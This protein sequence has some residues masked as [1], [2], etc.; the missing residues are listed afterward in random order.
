MKDEKDPPLSADYKKSQETGGPQ[1]PDWLANKYGALIGLGAVALIAALLYGVGHVDFSRPQVNP[2]E[3]RP[4]FAAL[5][6]HVENLAEVDTVCADKGERTACLCELADRI[7][8]ERRAIDT[9]L[10]TDPS[11]KGFAINIRQPASVTYNL[12]TLPKA[13]EESECLNAVSAPT[14]IDDSNPEK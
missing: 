12:Q 8:D 13:P 10:T 11:L 3:S 1:I 9:L 4:G 14:I 5:K 7:R 6:K 2:L